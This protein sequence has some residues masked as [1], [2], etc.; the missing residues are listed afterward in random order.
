MPKKGLFI[1]FLIAFF[2]LIALDAVF[3]QNLIVGVDLSLGEPPQLIVSVKGDAALDVTGIDYHFNGKSKSVDKPF[4]VA[5]GE[6]KAVAIDLPNPALPGSYNLTAKLKYVAQGKPATLIRNFFIPNVQPAILDVWVDVDATEIVDRGTISVDFHDPSL[7]GIC[8]PVFPDE[9]VVTDR[10]VKGNSIVYSVINTRADITEK[11]SLY[12]IF[13]KE[14]EIPSAEGALRVHQGG[15]LQIGLTLGNGSQPYHQ[16]I[17]RG[18]QT[19]NRNFVFYNFLSTNIVIVL[20]ILAFVFFIVMAFIYRGRESLIPLMYVSFAFFLI[21]VLILIFQIPFH[22]HPAIDLPVVQLSQPQVSISPMPVFNTVD[23]Y[24]YFRNFVLPVYYLCMIV[25]LVYSYADIKKRTGIE[26]WN[27]LQEKKLWR[28]FAFLYAKARKLLKQPYDER[29]AVW[30]APRKTAFLAILV[31]F[32]WMPLLWTWTINNIFVMIEQIMNMRADFYRVNEFVV[33]LIILLDV[34]IFA[35]SYTVE[36]KKTNSMIKS[37]EPTIL[38]WLVCIACYPP[39]NQF[40]FFWLDNLLDWMPNFQ[41]SEPVKIASSVVIVLCWAF[42]V[43]ATVALGFKASNLTNRGI[44]T[45]FPYSIVRH[46][47]YAAKNLLWLVEFFILSQKHLGLV[48]GFLIIYFLRAWT[49]E[50]HLKKDPDYA[51]YM[52]KVKYRFIPGII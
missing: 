11:T 42:Y 32:F 20:T 31:K 6:T 45:R 22:F 10:Q 17:G 38:G 26:L 29:D 44:V 43:A 15:W 5:P 50:R 13:E 37:V 21:N 4:S 48:L 49:E 52:K 7:I 36:S 30:D 8:T 46:P 1:S 25:Y 40:T 51:A 3:S 35:F 33:N 23:N 41:L 9:L 19:V 47:A 34:S 18:T 2:H 28:I 24:E 16:E 27:R 14:V 39:F 12:W